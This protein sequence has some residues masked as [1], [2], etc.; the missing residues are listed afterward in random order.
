MRAPAA[1]RLIVAAAFLILPSRSF[2]SAAATCPDRAYLAAQDCRF[3]GLTFADIAFVHLDGDAR[4]DFV[5][6][7]GGS[8]AFARC[9][10]VDDADRLQW[11]AFTYLSVP[12]G[13]SRVVSGDFDGDGHE[14]LVT[15]QPATK[16]VQIFRGNGVGGF[17]APVSTVLA[18]TPGRFMAADLDGNGR[19]EMVAQLSAGAFIVLHWDGA[20]LVAQ[21]AVSI[22]VTDAIVGLVLADQN[23]DG[24]LDVVVRYGRNYLSIVTCTGAAVNGDLQFA[25][26]VLAPVVLYDA[27]D[28]GYLG[29][30][31]MTDLSGDGVPDFVSVGSYRQTWAP[32]TGGAAVL[33]ADAATAAGAWNGSFLTMWGAWYTSGLAHVSTGRLTAGGPEELFFTD[34]FAILNWKPWNAFDIYRPTATPSGFLELADLNGDGH[35]DI[36]GRLQDAAGIVAVVSGCGTHAVPPEAPR[37]AGDW[38]ASGIELNTGAGPATAPSACA[39]GAGGLYVAWEQ[40]DGTGTRDVRVQHLAD[41]GEPAAG[42]P[43]VGLP[44]APAGIARTKP[45]VV[46]DGAGGVFVGWTEPGGVARLQHLAAD[47]MRLAGWD[48]AGAC[49]PLGCAPGACSSIKWQPVADDS[50]GVVAI[51]ITQISG[52]LHNV[53]VD[54]VRPDGTRAAGWPQG[55]RVIARSYSDSY[56]H[57]AIE[58][59]KFVTRTGGVTCAEI[60][61][62]T[63]CS[64]TAHGCVPPYTNWYYSLLGITDAGGLGSAYDYGTEPLVR[65]WPD[66]EG[67]LLGWYGNRTIKRLKFDQTLFWATNPV[68]AVLAGGDLVATPGGGA[69]LAV[70]ESDDAAPVGAKRL[71]MAQ[72]EANGQRAAGWPNK[73]RRLTWS[74][75]GAQIDPHLVRASDGKWWLFDQDSRSGTGSLFVMRLEDDAQ[76]SS[77]WDFGGQPVAENVGALTAMQA[78]AGADGAAYV[79][80]QDSR[81]GTASVYAQRVGPDLSVPVAFTALEPRVSAREVVLDWYVSDPPA[82]GFVVERGEAGEWRAIAQ[83]RADGAGHVR[84]TDRDVTP[85]R[86]YGW[87]LR[88]SEGTSAPVWATI[89]VPA[90]LA[91]RVLD[92]PRTRGALRVAAELAAG[93]PAKLEWF[94]VLG[95]RLGARELTLV[96]GEPAEVALEDAG[97]LP[98]GVVLVRLTA[99]AR[100]TRLRTVVLR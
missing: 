98:A 1:L 30:F 38:A 75:A 22:G 73:G 45:C 5:G 69:R 58:D 19:W 25:A 70:I 100:S 12:G 56:G 9:L 27:Y 64:E 83:A 24:R 23:V 4:A 93:G 3:P 68:D 20:K 35:Q 82:E 84:V 92:A 78:L 37:P 60:L 76:L 47:G 51:G 59:M 16:V 11:D 39:D 71:Y 14:D 77:G 66:G 72:I 99:G 96:A 31:V 42:W 63:Y 74:D 43:A 89:P 94:D 17:L 46:P 33:I 86:T 18:Q 36:I 52:I 44:V 97:A 65:L 62:E 85:G 79:V 8:L 32:Y 88:S 80:W 90:A 10:G 53:W 50:G 57:T 67:F 54:R 81:D 95:R 40:D 48:E 41:A 2:A 29:E 87:R 34:A 7:T 15:V 61:I 13:A 6:L 55:G 28:L 91:L 21:S 49:L 26:P